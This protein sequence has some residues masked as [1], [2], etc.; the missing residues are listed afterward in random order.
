MNSF[1][2]WHKVRSGCAEGRKQGARL[3]VWGVFFIYTW[4]I[5]YSST[6]S[7]ANSTV[8]GKSCTNLPG[9]KVVLQFKYTLLI[10]ITRVVNTGTHL[11]SNCRRQY[12][13]RPP[14]RYCCLHRHLCT[15]FGHQTSSGHGDFGEGHISNTSLRM[16][17]CENS[18]SSFAR[19]MEYTTVHTLKRKNKQA[20]DWGQEQRPC[21]V[22][23]L[24]QSKL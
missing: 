18:V 24:K 21:H 2:N 3:R 13:S 1:G 4:N 23:I 22:P 19:L 10:G 8:G 20:T 16:R 14:P 11:R 7:S 17:V 6:Y 9:V 15:A 5:I 12:R